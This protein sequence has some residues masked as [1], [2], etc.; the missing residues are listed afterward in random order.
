MSYIMLLYLMKKNAIQSIN[1]LFIQCSVILALLFVLFCNSKALI[2]LAS[3]YMSNYTILLYV[4]AKNKKK[5]RRKSVF[6][7]KIGKSYR[8]F[9]SIFNKTVIQLAL[10]GCEIIIVKTRVACSYVPRSLSTITHPTCTHGI[11]VK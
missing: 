10:V 1:Y 2:G 5:T 4:S 9:L 8:Y 11:I 3:W 7:N 6:R